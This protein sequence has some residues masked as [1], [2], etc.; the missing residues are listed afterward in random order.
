M[1]GDWGTFRG[2]VENDADLFENVS[3]LSCRNPDDV[4]DYVSAAASAV[5]ENYQRCH[6]NAEQLTALQLWISEMAAAT[7]APAH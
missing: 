2:R 6:E 7:Q 1:P 3:K 5:A 4:K